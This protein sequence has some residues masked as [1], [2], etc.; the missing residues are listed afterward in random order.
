MD[1]AL[2]S[3]ASDLFHQMV[4][5]RMKSLTENIEDLTMLESH[6]L[7]T[8]SGEPNFL[9]REIRQNLPIPASTLTS[10]IDRLERKRYLRRVINPRDRRSYGLK[11]TKSGREAEAA[12]MKLDIRLT[13]EFI[14]T[15]DSEKD[16]TLLLQLLA[17][18]ARKRLP[19]HD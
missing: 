9:L 8:V 3:L 10:A 4:F 16:R 18:I 15:L 11:L 13:R 2:L 7:K 6:I 19:V 1:A 14:E 12:H 5:D 17:K